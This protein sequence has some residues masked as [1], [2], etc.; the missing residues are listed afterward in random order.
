[1]SLRKSPQLTPR[2]TTSS[3]KNGK[4]WEP[5]KLKKTERT[6]NVYENKEPVSAG[7]NRQEAEN[8]NFSRERISDPLGPE[9]C[10]GRREMSS[11][12]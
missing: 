11:E 10:A 3:P 5:A 12:A 4:P 8:V 7:I 2:K 6:W 9:F 1:M